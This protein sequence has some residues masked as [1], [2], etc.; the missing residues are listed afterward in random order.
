VT[1]EIVA[2]L[3]LGP[4]LFGHFFPETAAGLLW[5]VLRPLADWLVRHF[6]PRD[7]TLSPN[8]MALVL[9]LIFAP[10]IYTNAIGVFTI[11]GGFAA[12]LLFHRHAEFVEAWRRQAG[13]FVLVFFLPVYVAGRVS[14]FDHWQSAELG[15][16]MNT[17]GLMELIALNVGYDLGFLPQKTFTMLVIMAVT[18]TIMTGPL[19]Q[20]LLPRIGHAMRERVPA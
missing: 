19:L 6:P 1:G 14:G 11:F 8:L 15:S 18:T 9:C 17:R 16:L 7:A 13:Q 4:S 3:L 20:V 2:G 10:G 5:F 12:G